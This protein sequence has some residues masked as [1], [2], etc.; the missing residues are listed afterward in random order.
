MGFSKYLLISL[1]VFPALLGAQSAKAT[2]SGM[3]KD[4]ATKSPL[5]F[6]TVM[7]KSAKDSSLIS[8]SISNEEGRFSATDLSSGT[9]ILELSLVGYRH[10]V[11]NIEVGKL[12][13]FL[14]LGI[15]ELQAEAIQLGEVVVSGQQD[16]VSSRMDKK[17]F[18]LADNLSLSGASGIGFLFGGVR[19][20]DTLTKGN[21]YGFS[22]QDGLQMPHPHTILILGNCPL[23]KLEYHLFYF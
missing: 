13:S 12:S 19:Y 21:Q 5:S 8:G 6:V 23:P 22:C 18:S 11:Q 20:N 4:A 3:V 15:I 14:D 1:L 16:E 17:T 9:Y 7:F 2:L 10:M